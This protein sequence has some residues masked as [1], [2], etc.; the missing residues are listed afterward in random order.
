VGAKFGSSPD[1]S[2]ELAGRLFRRKPYRALMVGMARTI[3]FLGG[4]MVAGAWAWGCGGSDKGSGATCTSPAAC[5]GTPDGTWQ[6]DSVCTEGDLAGA[7]ASMQNL[8]AACRQ[9]FQSATMTGTGTVTLAN[10]VETDNVTQKFVVTGVCTP[11]CFTAMSQVSMALNSTI[12]SALGQQMTGSNGITAASCSLSGA[13]CAC[14]ITYEQ[15]A[16]TTP[17]P[18]TISG[19]TLTYTSSDQA[20]LTYCVAGTTLTGS[21][22]VTGLSGVTLHTTLHKL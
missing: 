19:N 6:I 14:S 15:Q 12:C 22:T 18:Y 8:A 4:I 1:Q 13:N 5:G 20:P 21:Q 17:Q 10:G 7:I 3:L 16:P 11:E 9:M 2:L